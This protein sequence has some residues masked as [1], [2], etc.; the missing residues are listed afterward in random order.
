MLKHQV[1][2]DH[3][4]ISNF[5]DDCGYDLDLHFTDAEENTFQVVVQKPAKARQAFSK[6]LKRPKKAETLWARETKWI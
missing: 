4:R 1:R 5:P 6:S 2:D 3:W